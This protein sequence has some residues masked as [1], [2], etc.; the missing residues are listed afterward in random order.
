MILERPEENALIAELQQLRIKFLESNRCVKRNSLDGLLKKALFAEKRGV[1]VLN[2]ES[3]EYSYDFT[4]SLF[5]VTTFLTTTG[6]GSTM[7]MSDGGKLFLVM[8]SVVGIPITMLLLSSITHRLLPY[9]THGPVRHIQARWGVSQ[10]QAALTH[11]GLLMALTA[12]LFFLLPATAFCYLVPGWSFLESLYFC[13]ISLS[14][15][16]LGDYLP[17]GTHSLA[18]WQG[19]E[20]AISCYLF[21]GLMVLLVVMETLWELPQAKALIRFFSGPQESKINGLALDELI[22]TRDSLPPLNLMEKG[23]SKKEPQYCLPTSTIFPATS[24]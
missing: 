22:L 11:A 10:A 15:I 17:G 14:T 5:F 9:V 19:L 7:P 6:Y 3:Q 21:L 2:A 24:D 12:G 4:S 23:P 8:Y 20:F 1:A 13:Y 18:E 16:G